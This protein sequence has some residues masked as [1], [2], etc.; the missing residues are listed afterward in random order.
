MGGDS[1]RRNPTTL[2][3]PP[4]ADGRLRPRRRPP[5]HSA[6]PPIRKTTAPRNPLSPERVAGSAKSRTRIG[7]SISAASSAWRPNQTPTLAARRPAIA[8]QL[9]SWWYRSQARMSRITGGKAAYQAV[10]IVSGTLD[11]S[12]RRAKPRGRAENRMLRPR[13]STICQIHER[14][15]CLFITALLCEWANERVE[16]LLDHRAITVGWHAR[17][18]ARRVSR[19]PFVPNALTGIPPQAPRSGRGWVARASAS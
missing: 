12:S 15:R 19:R 3:D 5:I 18:P 16:P 2:I 11:L 9:V 4:G 6:R 7:R 8:A 13:K 14:D 1:L 17:G 10:M